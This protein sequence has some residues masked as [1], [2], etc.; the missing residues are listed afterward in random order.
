MIDPSSRPPLLTPDQVLV[1]GRIIEIQFKESDSYPCPVERIAEACEF[2]PPSPELGSLERSEINQAITK[3]I[4][5]GLLSVDQ[6]S[7]EFSYRHRVSE[8]L[9]LGSAQLALITTFMLNGAQTLEELLHN[10]H[11][12]YPFQDYQHIAETLKS[13]QHE[14]QHPLVAQIPRH[15]GNKQIRYLH[16]LLPHEFDA[17]TLK[18]IEVATT[19]ELQI[20]E[21]RNRM[22]DLE[23]RVAE[24]EAMIDKLT[25]GDDGDDGTA[26]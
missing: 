23:N 9:H 24:L 22:N 14:R 16:C 20:L 21:P 17:A 11:P 1:L 26:R 13:L 3:L 19:E 2:A 5:Q 12:L 25:G 18:E 15:S 8:C 4:R 10:T 6:D 7:V